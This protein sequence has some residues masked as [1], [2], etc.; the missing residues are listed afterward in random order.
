MNPDFSKK[1]TLLQHFMGWEITTETPVFNPEIGT[2]MDFSLSQQ[3]GITFM[4]IL[5]VSPNRALVEYT[6]FTGEVLPKEEYK[7]SKYQKR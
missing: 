7:R 1:D 2:L 3:H 4:Y 5:P 6:L